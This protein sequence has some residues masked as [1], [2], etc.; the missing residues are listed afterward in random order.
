ME[1]KIKRTVTEVLDCIT[2]ECIDADEFFKK[3]LD[4]ITVFRSELQKAIEGFREPLFTC[5]YCKQRI[6]IRG[7][8]SLVKKRK[9]EI[10]HFAH[11]K[12]S[13]ECHIKTKHHY[14]REEVDRIKYN[15]AKESALHQTLKEKIAE[16]LRRNQETKGEI[17]RVE[18][19]KVIKDKV[20]NEWKKPDINAYFLDKRIAIELQLSTTWLDVITKRQQFYKE[21]GIFI[22]WVFQSFNP[23]D[24][25]RKL[26]YNDVI[27]TNNQNA[28]IFDK[29][30]YEVSKKEND[31]ILKCYYKSFYRDDL[32]ISEKWEYALIKLSDLAFDVQGIRMYYHDSFGQKKEVKNILEEHLD[33]LRESGRLK[34]LE[35][36]E[37]KRK[38]K[39]LEEQIEFLAEDIK[40]IEISQ[41]EIE[42]KI[43]KALQH[44]EQLKGFIDNLI[45]YVEKTVKYLSETKNHSK[46]FYNND[47]LLKALKEEFE[48]R[49]TEA[50][51][52]IILIKR[53]QENCTDNIASIDNLTS[54]EISSK[55][56]SCINNSTDWEFIRK[57]YSKIRVI[58][59]QLVSGLFAVAELREIKSEFE[60]TRLQFSKDNL[61]LID[62]SKQLSEFKKQK[63]ENQEIIDRHAA[64][65]SAMKDQVKQR[66]EFWN[67]KD[68]REI[69]IK[70]QSY[71]AT[72]AKLSETLMNKKVEK[73][74][75]DSLYKKVV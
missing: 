14:T 1:R 59:K 62:F 19:E 54:V 12:D 73:I 55:S 52:K 56:Y 74:R 70:L 45:Q 50:A 63:K 15:G 13:D 60:L 25:V 69:E 35:E 24:D 20:A 53:E 3:S 10:F 75:L 37:E 33:K 39:E 8:I 61:F 66:M 49:L 42:G 38:R 57:N 30:A 4:E 51:E 65:L 46:P 18:V 21:Q 44:I 36:Q 2:G 5:Y 64:F 71:E 9:I 48:A 16:C 22:F 47:A 28:Y 43:R 23:N 40:E 27:Y 67:Q 26:T 17:S 6:R 34:F 29:E 68:L 11:L 41:T 31:L 32:N 7:G 58:N 72:K